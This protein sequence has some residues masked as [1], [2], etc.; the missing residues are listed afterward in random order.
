MV[1]KLF[2]LFL[3]FCL[4][5][6]FAEETVVEADC[7]AEGLNVCRLFEDLLDVETDSIAR[8]N[9]RIRL[10]IDED[11]YDLRHGYSVIVAAY[12]KFQPELEM[13]DI[14]VRD[15]YQSLYDT[16]AFRQKVEAFYQDWVMEFAQ[17]DGNPADSCA[18]YMHFVKL[19]ICT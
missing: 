11:D 3:V 1:T 6:S 19:R 14:L 10:M 16:D 5:F 4:S 2:G 9:D 17:S 7:D 8:F 12:F 18:Q 15:I 13:T